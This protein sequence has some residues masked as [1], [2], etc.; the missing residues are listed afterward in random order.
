MVKSCQKAVVDDLE[1]VNREIQ[2]KIN[3]LD[4]VVPLRLHQVN[5]QNCDCVK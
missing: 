3:Q 2:Q 1:L 5:I 4:V